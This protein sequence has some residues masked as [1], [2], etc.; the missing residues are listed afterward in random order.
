M[1]ISRGAARFLVAFGVWSW[2]IWL[3]FAKNIAKDHGRATSF[4]VVHGV[5]IA[6]SLAFGTAVGVIGWRALRSG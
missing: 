3:T 6:V 2:V 4:Y 1:T 5:L